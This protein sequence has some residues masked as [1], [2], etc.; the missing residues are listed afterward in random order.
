MAK[1]LPRNAAP[2]PF[3]N[4]VLRG[5]QQSTLSTSPATYASDRHSTLS[6]WGEQ[7]S[8]IPTRSPSSYSEIEVVLEDGI[9]QKRTVS[10]STIPEPEPQSLSDED[11]TMEGSDENTSNRDQQ[12]GGQQYEQ[13][14]PRR[15]TDLDRYIQLGEK[16]ETKLVVCLFEKSN[17]EYKQKEGCIGLICL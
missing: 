7:V 9:I 15:N 17:D 6:Q 4:T 16:K 5:E 1:R 3:P 8:D 2:I 13:Q 12:A 10:L 11:S 14:M